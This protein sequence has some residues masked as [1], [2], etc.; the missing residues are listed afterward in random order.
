MFSHV[1]AFR[2]N[3]GVNIV[4]TPDIKLFKSSTATYFDVEPAAFGVR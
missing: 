4:A 1:N 3:L 2:T